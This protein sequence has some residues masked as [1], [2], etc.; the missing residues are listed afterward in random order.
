MSLR[1]K[2]FTILLATVLS[3]SAACVSP[4]RVRNEVTS[5]PR[6]CPYRTAVLSLAIEA[7][8]NAWLGVPENR[9][10]IEKLIREELERVGLSVSGAGADLLAIYRLSARDR[11]PKEAPDNVIMASEYR[12][13]TL[14]LELRDARDTRI[15]WRTRVDGVVGSSDE[16]NLTRLRKALRR[17]LAPLQACQAPAAR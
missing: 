13:G 7:P 6:P 11:T 5:L 3:M 8:P 12:Q 17:G 4:V 14:I 15:V 1:M 10:A 9:E 2:P 16:Q